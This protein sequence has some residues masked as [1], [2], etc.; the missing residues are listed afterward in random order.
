MKRLALLLALLP[1]LAA[2]QADPQTLAD[3][4]GQIAALSQEIQGL[5]GEL[6]TTGQLSTGVPGGSALDRL[7]AIEAEL[8]G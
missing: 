8:H 7:N 3:I 6:S 5:R 2:A 1:S 4:R